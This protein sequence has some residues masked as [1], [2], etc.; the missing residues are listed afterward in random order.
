M[1]S[2]TTPRLVLGAHI[3]AAGAF[4][5]AFDRAESIGCTTM[6]I[7]TKSNR[8]WYAKPISDIEAQDF[9]QRAA[10][11]NVHPVST[12]ASYLINLGAQDPEIEAKS[13]ESLTVELARCTKLG[14]PYLVLHPGS[15]GAQTAHDCLVKIAANINKV[16]N[17]D[18]GTTIICLEN[19]AGH[20]S[21]VGHQFEQLAFLRNNVAKKDR[22]GFCFDTCHAFAAGYDIRTK[23]AYTQTLEQ[24]NTVVGLEHLKVMHLNDSKKEL[25]CHVDR[26]ED[27]GKGAIGLEAFRLIMNDERLFNVAKILETPYDDLESYAQNLAVLKGLISDDTKKRLQL[28]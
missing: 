23:E 16:L 7:F 22:V 11:S 13:V 6:Q 10:T 25:G 14:I 28:G 19:M 18:T 20:G 15:A 8:Q 26:H 1:S 27:I 17:N 9:M 4:S 2:T 5:L 21:S 3:S 12:H 24:F